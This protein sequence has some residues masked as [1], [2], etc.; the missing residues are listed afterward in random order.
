[1]SDAQAGSEPQGQFGTGLS[2]HARL[3]GL[4]TA[5]PSDQA[6]S[7]MAEQFDGREAV[8][9]LF[10]FDVDALSTA[11]SLDLASFIG[12]EMTLTLLQ[13]DGSQRAW[14]GLCTDCAWLGADGGVARYR[15]RLEPALALLRLRR[16]SYIFQDKNARDIVGELLADYPQVRHRID[17]SQPLATR[18]VWTQYRESDFDFLAR[19]LAFEGLN[20]RFEHEQP[21]GAQDGGE[22]QGQSRHTLVIFDSKASAPDT[23]GGAE[24]RFHGVRASDSDDAIDSFGARRQ[25]QS[26]AVGISSWDPQQVTAPAAEHASSLDAGT[27]PQLAVYDGAGER[28]HADRAAAD[29]HGARMLQALELENKQFDGAGAVRRLAAGH[30]FRL[31]QHEQYADGANQFNV[32][33]VEHQARNTA[34][35]AGGGLTGAL[36]RLAKVASLDGVADWIAGQIE[37]GTYRNTFGCVRSSVA[38]VPRATAERA[39][40]VALGPQ[41]ALV[42]GLADSVATTGRDH[43]VRIQ[44]AWQR[45]AAANPGGLAHNTDQQGNAPGNEASGTWV[46]VAEAL[47]GP[48][49]GS[50]FTP[51]IGTEVLIDF[52]EGDMDR[53]LV[54]AQLYTGS[55]APPYAAG[56]DAN[57][58]HAGVLSGIHSSNF[59]GA[60]YNQWVLDDTPGQLR[61][62][63]ASSSAATELNLGYL[64]QQ[65]AASAQRGVYRGSGFE[66]RT[67]AWA[68]LRAGEGLLLSATARARQG[69]SVASTQLDTREALNLL[70]GAS[71]LS[72]ATAVAAGQQRA[73]VSK[74]A[75]QAQLDLAGQIDPQ[76]DGKYQN[77]VGGHEAFKAGNGARAPDAAQPV[78]RY[79]KPLVL[80][81]GPNSINWA[82]PAST[83]LFAGQHLHATAQTDLHLA[84]GHTVASV[85][86]HAA[87][88]F[89]Q[90]GGISAIAGNGP[91]SLQAHTD[92]LEILADKSITVISVSDVI[93]IKANQKI[94]VQ[95][96]QSSITLEGGDITFQCPGNFTVKGGQHVFNG[97]ASA[98]AGLP[99]LPDS[100]LKLFDEGFVLKDRDTGELMPRQP[101]RVKRA[102]GT[103]ETGMTD[104]K[105]LTHV[106]AAAAVEALVIEL[107]KSPGHAPDEAESPAPAPAPAPPAPAKVPAG[108][109]PAPGTTAKAPQHVPPARPEPKFKDR[110]TSSTS[111]VDN[112]Q[113]KEVLIKRPACWIADYEKEISVSSV[114]RYNNTFGASG[115]PHNYFDNVR[116]KIYVPVKSNT[117]IIAELR[118]KVITVL[119][120]ADQALEDR[121]KG[122]PQAATRAKQRAAV[123]K[124]VK[125]IAT[126]GLES[127]W[128]NKFQM[129]ISDPECGT[130]TLP[131]IYRV[132]YVESNEHY[133]M[134]IHKRYD[135][136]SVT[137]TIIDVSASTDGQTHAH[138]FGHCYG[139]PDE[140]SYVEGDDETV[141]YKKPDGTWDA[142]V[143]SLSDDEEPEPAAANIMNSAGSIVIRDRHAWQIAIEVQDLLRTKIGRQIKCDIILNGS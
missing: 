2:Q 90:D 1:M 12:E 4:A 119:E 136:E 69:S 96:G 86:A 88:L 127:H 20:W 118:V 43:Q 24:L 128:N 92:Q 59:D 114:P 129:K 138:E 16:D 25:V 124:Y 11:A 135:R 97:G 13:P 141:K 98:A 73:L 87:T 121:E 125:G 68:M 42:V 84:A 39:P 34:G 139:L 71:E 79:A 104:D 93:E 108:R 66:L 116:Y 64:V 10:R 137:G 32:L 19:V 94:T 65:G 107:L 60:G 31:L 134:Q 130:R 5:Q 99:P 103:Y 46:R 89:S 41:T 82:T 143:P 49:W 77:S 44:F 56:V 61:T 113:R 62:R 80:M 126:T 70:R 72:K 26:N 67:D 117:G 33:W 111:P 3:I 105:G 122:T 48:N 53:P 132:V 47:A 38:I 142:P 109:A 8:N 9:E 140:Y 95:A 55:D 21:G 110:A 74:D 131:I 36:S 102:D 115:A 30:A 45:G 123:I 100:R 40:A 27:L 85:A 37:A 52:I 91:V 7:L 17:I 50:Q 63:L 35:P 120:P 54:V 28:R 133:V 81:E 29:P 15:L 18:A 112:K 23:P 57:V 75:N 22:G 106:V 78:E 58:N 101:Y 76:Q 83:V 6:Q 51:R 14:H